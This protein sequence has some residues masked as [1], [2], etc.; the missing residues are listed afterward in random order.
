MLRTIRRSK[1]CRTKGNSR[2]E[3]DRWHSDVT[4]R[5]KP[6]YVTILQAI[7]SAA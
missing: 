1:Y 7:E 2:P 5:E 4:F 6:S 3:T